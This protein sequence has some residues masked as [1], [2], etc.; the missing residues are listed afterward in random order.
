M[1]SI[2]TLRSVLATLAAPESWSAD[3][4]DALAD[5]LRHH[6]VQ[7]S[8]TFAPVFLEG[9][10]TSYL[11]CAAWATPHR[12]E[13]T[14]EVLDDGMERFEW[15]PESSETAVRLIA[16]FYLDNCELCEAAIGRQIGP[17][18][19]RGDAERYT[20]GQLGH[21]LWLTRNGHGAGFWDSGLPD[22]LG[23][24]LS[25]VA[26]KMGETGCW[27]DAHDVLHLDEEGDL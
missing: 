8:G 1:D 20:W 15:A 19:G 10:A 12:N 23:E 5:V 17:S 25:A 7:G 26:R 6:C 14:G 9:A 11:A 2:T 22:G 13:D 27:L 18:G 3:T 21:D 24:R 16:G 4:F